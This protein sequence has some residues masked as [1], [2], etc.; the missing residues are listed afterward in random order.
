GRL[1][2]N[3]PATG[4][5]PASATA[6]A[7]SRRCSPAAR[8]P[9]PAHRRSR[10]CPR[11]TTARCI[12]L[13][14]STG[15]QQRLLIKDRHALEPALEERATGL[16]LAVGQPSERLLQALHGPAQA[17]QPLARSR[18]P[19]GVLQPCLDPLLRDRGHLS[20]LV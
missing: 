8:R 10:L 3:G 7:S 19:P 11:G 2:R 14:V 12:P 4:P 17:L 9:R 18:D 15:R 1:G 13:N 5:R 6:P 16:L 20:R